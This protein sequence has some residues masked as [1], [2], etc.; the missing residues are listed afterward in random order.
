MLRTA[1]WVTPKHPDKLC[2]RIGD[3]ILIE[4]LKCDPDVHVAIETTGGHGRIF[5]TGE[6]GWSKPLEKFLTAEQVAKI[7]REITGMR[8]KDVDVNIFNQ[9]PEIARG[10]EKEQGAGDQGIMV[11]YACN[12]NGEM[13]PDELFLARKLGKMIY[14][15]YPF[16]GKTQITMD[17]K[18]V[19]SIVASFQNTSNAEL[20]DCI[21]EFMDYLAENKYNGN[22]AMVYLNPA[23]EWKIGGFDADA[24]TTGRKLAVDNYGPRVPLGGGA[25]SGK[26]ASKVDRSGAYIARK[27]AV[28]ELMGGRGRWDEVV[29]KIAYAIGVASPLMITA[30]YYHNERIV[31]TA[32]ITDKYSKYCKPAKI[33]EILDL[34]NPNTFEDLASIGH[35]S[36]KNEWDKPFKND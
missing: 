31:D 28:T 16:D 3:E 35:F 11:G 26:D 32:D 18:R 19:K 7:A 8:T 2:D 30:E 23:G 15:K 10:I 12:D 24:G 34:K 33:I 17:G 22:G 36:D 21:N 6:I 25:F 13:I 9:S 14:V 27:I 1:E 4:C 29:V 20:S 5:I